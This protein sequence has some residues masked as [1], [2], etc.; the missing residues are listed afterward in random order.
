MPIAEPSMLTVE[1]Q[2]PQPPPAAIAMPSSSREQITVCTSASSSRSSFTGCITESGNNTEKVMPFDLRLST[3]TRAT[4]SRN[5]E[6]FAE[7]GM[8][9]VY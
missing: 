7:A 6:R 5:V 8:S 2:P 4:S 1:R 9:K 3:N